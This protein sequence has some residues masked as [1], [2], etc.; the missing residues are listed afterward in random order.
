MS[1]ENN[2]KVTTIGATKKT[3]AIRE[4][5]DAFRTSMD[6]GQL[7]ITSGVAALGAV[8]VHRLIQRVRTFDAFDEGNDPHGEHDFGSI[9]EGGEKY[10][11]KIDYH[12]PLM[13][14]GSEDPADPTKTRRVLTILRADE[15]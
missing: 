13:E 6:G 9:E 7:T 5:N 3:R 10:F 15:W 14:F 4:L 2:P 8:A 1:T 12:C 11:W